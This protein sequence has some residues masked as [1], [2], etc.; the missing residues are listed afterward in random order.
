MSKKTLAP[1][2][3]AWTEYRVWAAGAYLTKTRHAAPDAAEKEARTYIEAFGDGWRYTDQELTAW[4]R[5][6]VVRQDC[7][8]THAFPVDTG[9][10]NMP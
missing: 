5:R 10:G 7:V 8:M 4:A 6:L 3:R 1:L 2:S 9:D